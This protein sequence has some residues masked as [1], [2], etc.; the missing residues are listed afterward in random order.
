MSAPRDS[1]RAFWKLSLAVG[2]LLLV[3]V[4]LYIL[5]GTLFPKHYSLSITPGSPRTRRTR[6]ATTLADQLQGSRVKLRVSATVGSEE[7]LGKVNSHELDLALVQ[8]GLSA[9][10]LGDVRQVAAFYAEPLHLLVK[11]DLHAAVTKDLAA[12]KGKRINLS[13]H[14]SGTY[15]LSR[16]VLDFAGLMAPE[17]GGEGDYL[18]T[19]LGKNDLVILG[20]QLSAAPPEQRPELLKRLP[21]AIFLVESLPS[22]V[23]QVLVRA[24]DYRLVPLPFAEAFSL[25]ELNDASAAT[26][27]LEP[28]LIKPTQIPPY[29]YQ[30]TPAVPPRHCSTLGTSLLLVAHKAVPEDAVY[31]LL[32]TIYESHFALVGH[33]QPLGD[34]TPEYP[35]HQGAVA[36]RDRDRPLLS[37]ELLDVL[38]KL[39]TVWVFVCATSYAVRRF[40]LRDPTK[41]FVHYLWE[42]TQL[43][44][45]ARGILDDP[46]APREPLERVAYLEDKLSLL[47]AQMIQEFSDTKLYQEGTMGTVMSLISD[48]RASLNAQRLNLEGG[49]ESNGRHAAPDPQEQQGK[50]GGQAPPPL[51]EEPRNVGREGHQPGFAFGA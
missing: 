33:P 5:R 24:A 42:F 13:Q 48:T 17:D 41:R 3:G 14:G 32:K 45:V 11:E 40:F 35:L 47:K 46:G 7:A 10:G 18:P 38:A 51:R 1:L 39:I 37:R 30:V 44:L 21:D 6:V 34:T 50:P 12:L 2:G 22:D 28:G 26:T 15:L 23:A 8:G 29:L 4:T 9:R 36:Y 49:R 20:E 31:P 16:A 19:T 25:S 43:D 27:R